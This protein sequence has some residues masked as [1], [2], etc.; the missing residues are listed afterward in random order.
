MPK[1]NRTRFSVHDVEVLSVWFTENAYPDNTD[2]SSMAVILNKSNRCVKVWF[3]NKRQRSRR[4]N[5]TGCVPME[6]LPIACFEEPLHLSH[7]TVHLVPAVEL[8]FP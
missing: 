2:V 7:L 5:V 4:R 1:W 3:Q 6:P 8:S